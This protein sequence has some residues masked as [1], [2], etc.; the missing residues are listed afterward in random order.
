ME[1]G[2]GCK[3]GR[4]GLMNGNIGFKKSKLAE[5]QVFVLLLFQVHFAQVPLLACF[6]DQLF[7]F[8]YTAL[9]YCTDGRFS[10]GG[11]GKSS[12]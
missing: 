4:H 9:S 1:F 10:L 12:I 5:A 11:A 7:S 6:S 3:R 2:G 8:V